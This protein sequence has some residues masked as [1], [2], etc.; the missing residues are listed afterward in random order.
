MEVVKSNCCKTKASPDKK[1]NGAGGS[2]SL[3]S[4]ILLILLPKCPFCFA[5][6]LSAMA[7]F[8]DMES[9]QLVPVLIHVKPLLG[10]II[11]ALILLNQRGRRTW[12]SLGIAMAAMAFLI[13]KTYFNTAVLPDWLIYTAFFFSVWYNGNFKYFYR[14]VRFGRQ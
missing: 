3:F 14:F 4:T 11:I 9:A 8:F 12:I 5:A 6:Y 13:L 7:L 1:Q 2:M 10:L